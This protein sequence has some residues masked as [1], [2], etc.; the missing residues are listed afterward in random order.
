M[1]YKKYFLVNFILGY[2]LEEGQAKKNYE[3]VLNLSAG[4][5]TMFVKQVVV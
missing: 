2:Y 5:S 4:Q 1:K 3:L